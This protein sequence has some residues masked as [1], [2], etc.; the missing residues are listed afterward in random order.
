MLPVG[1]HVHFYLFIFEN[2]VYFTEIDKPAYTMVLFHI[3]NRGFCQK[4]D[5]I[6]SHC[7]TVHVV[8][9]IFYANFRKENNGAAPIVIL[10][11]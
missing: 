2:V 5:Y 11:L 9:V 7:F 6:C 10:N 4:Q 8:F 1:F 3:N